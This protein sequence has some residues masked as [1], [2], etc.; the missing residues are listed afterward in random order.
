[1]DS[2]AQSLLNTFP[3][4]GHSVGASP[5]Q[6]GPKGPT[7]KVEDDPLVS[8]ALVYLFICTVSVAFE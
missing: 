7:N 4:S 6:A 5:S 1:M 3:A 2:T 8:S